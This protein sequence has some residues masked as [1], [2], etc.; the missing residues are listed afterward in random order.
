MSVAAVAATVV[1]A[2]VGHAAAQGDEMIGYYSWNWG[3]GSSGPKNATFGIGFT[4]ITDV[5]AAI[6]GYDVTAGWCCPALRGEKYISLGGGNAAGS[7]DETSLATLKDDLNLVKAAD[8]NGVVFDIEICH[9]S[10]AVLVPAFRKAFVE[11]KR[12]GL[13]VIVTFSHSAPYETDAPADAVAMVKA[14]VDDEN[15]D[16]LSP[17]L[18]TSGT[19]ATPVFDE[20]TSCRA[21]G[22][23]W[24][25]FK[26]A[27]AKFV[28]SIVSEEQYAAVK[29]FFGGSVPVDGFIQWRQDDAAAVAMVIQTNVTTGTNPD[30]VKFSEQ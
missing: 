15:I 18:Y 30:R 1:A 2:P 19:E 29:A 11:A 22:C 3:K 13:K 7:F 21:A 16:A 17:Q 27:K 10:A 6:S 14:W 9:G 4:G 23:K 25:L 28:P 20:S 5:Q 26:G 24:D 12:L 8:Y